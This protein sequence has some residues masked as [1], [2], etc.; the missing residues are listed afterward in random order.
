MIR[1]SK[2]HSISRKNGYFKCHVHAVRGA[3]SINAGD[4]YI[5]C[6]KTYPCL[7]S[8]HFAMTEIGES[9]QK[10]MVAASELLDGF[11]TGRTK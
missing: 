6:V 4:E 2:L 10:V 7:L 9:G 8:L 5:K 11:P 1:I 3:N